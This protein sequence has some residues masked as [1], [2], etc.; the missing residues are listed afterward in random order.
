MYLKNITNNCN[1]LLLLV[2]DGKTFFLFMKNIESPIN[3]LKSKS[4]NFSYEAKQVMQHVLKQELK[5]K[6]KCLSLF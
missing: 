1:V 5:G 6:I 4:F 2:E 3:Y